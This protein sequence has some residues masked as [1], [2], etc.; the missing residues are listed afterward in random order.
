MP[1]RLDP[2][3]ARSGIIVLLVDAWATRLETIRQALR[4][5]DQRADAEVAVLVPA[6]RDDAETTAYQTELRTAVL[7]TFP[8]RKRRRDSTFRTDIQTVASFDD[9]LATA[10]A[11]ARQRIYRSRQTHR[12]PTT[13]RAGRRPI[14]E[15]P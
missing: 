9:D 14:L 15:G 10:L 4:E 6:S 11:E 8:G 13:G 1:D 5:I 2:T 12:Q 7:G 3:A